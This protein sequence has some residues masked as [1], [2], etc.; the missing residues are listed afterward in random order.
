MIDAAYLARK[1]FFAVGRT[2]KLRALAPKSLAGLGGILMLHRVSPEN[3]SPLGVNAGLSVTPEFLD[4][5]VVALKADGYD[6]IALDDLP[7]RLA[8]PQEKPFLAVTF[9][10]GYKDN[11]EYAYP[12]LRRNHVP[13]TVYI[14]PGLVNSETFLWWELLELA[15]VRMEAADGPF[16]R[17]SCRSAGEKAAAFAR[18]QHWLLHDCPETD[19]PAFIRDLAGKAGMDAAGYGQAELL[20]WAAI[21]ALSNDPLCTIGTHTMRHYHLARLSPE[22]LAIE[23]AEAHATLVRETGLEPQHVAY[24][25]GYRIA[26]GRRETVEAGNRRYKTGVTTRHGMLFQGHAQDMTALPRISLNGLHQNAGDVRLMLSGI[27]GLLA[28]RRI[29]PVTL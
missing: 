24:P 1:S 18:I 17:L 22:Q 21:R 20:D 23:F 12:V 14:A 16:G 10:D 28:S 15:L 4:S 9:D 29:G 2:L 13:W 19:V 3:R 8:R 26:V 6:F 27:T 11:A 5:L 25:Y 7:E